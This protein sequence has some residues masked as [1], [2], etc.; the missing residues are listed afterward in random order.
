MDGR[1]GWDRDVD[2]LVHSPPA[3]PEWAR[4]R[5]MDRPDEPR[6]GDVGPCAL[7]PALRIPDRLCER[8]ALGLEGVHLGEVARA[9][10]PDVRE[11]ARLQLLRRG[12]RIP[13]RDELVANP[14]RF[15]GPGGDDPNRRRREPLR[16]DRRAPLGCRLRLRETNVAGDMLVLEPDPTQE[17]VVVDE[18]REALRRDQERQQVRRVLHVDRPY[19]R[20]EDGDSLRVLGAKTLEPPRLRLQADAQPV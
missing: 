14:A 13:T 6:P 20:L 3:H 12:Q 4:Y 16:L 8:R 9:R 11:C 19:P 5:T 18:L 1:A 10:F 15:L 17:V 7:R 2:S